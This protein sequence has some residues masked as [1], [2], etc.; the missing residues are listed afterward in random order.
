MLQAHSYLF[1]ILG[2]HMKSQDEILFKGVGRVV[3]PSVLHPKSFTKICHEHDVYVLM[4]VIEYVDKFL[5][6]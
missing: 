6:T 2:T 1:P 5:V 3:T 4:H